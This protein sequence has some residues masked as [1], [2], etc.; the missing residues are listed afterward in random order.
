[1]IVSVLADVETE[2]RGTSA[3]PTEPH[4]KPKITSQKVWA[5]PCLTATDSSSHILPCVN[6]RFQPKI[7][8]LKHKKKW[9]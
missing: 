7:T 8:T 3:M 6:R 2:M 9:C 1:M 5:T 4:I